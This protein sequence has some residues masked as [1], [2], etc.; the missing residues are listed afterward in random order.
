MRQN[1]PELASQNQRDTPQLSAPR[2]APASPI[3]ERRAVPTESQFRVSRRT[4]MWVVHW[5][6]S[7]P[8]HGGDSSD[9]I[10]L[11]KQFYGFRDGRIRVIPS[12][13]LVGG[14]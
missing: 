9:D 11:G 3:T 6:G 10:H 5:S 14:S 8:K 13:S 1:A 4:W 12:G 7:L 2:I